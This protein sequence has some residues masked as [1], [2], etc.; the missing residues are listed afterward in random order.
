VKHSVGVGFMSR[1]TSVLD[2]VQKRELMAGVRRSVGF[3]RSE[4]LMADATTMRILL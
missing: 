2:E 1:E 3:L 4:R